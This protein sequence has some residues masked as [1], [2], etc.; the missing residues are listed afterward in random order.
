MIDVV[1]ETGIVHKLA[2]R[3]SKAGL[4]GSRIIW[5][6]AKLLSPFPEG[7][8]RLPDGFLLKFD[9]RDWNHRAIY[10]GL[11]DRALCRLVSKIKFK[12]IFIDVGANV[13]YISYLTC[14]HKQVKCLTIEPISRNSEQ[15]KFSLN[16]LDIPY[17]HISA[18]VADFNGYS[19]I[20]GGQNPDHSGAASIERV[21]LGKFG[22]EHVPTFLLDELARK[23]LSQKEISSPIFVKID[24]EGAEARVIAGMPMLLSQPNFFGMIIE[25]SPNFGSIEYLRH[26]ERILSK[27]YECFLIKEKVKLVHAQVVATKISWAMALKLSTQENLLIVKDHN[28]ISGLKFSSS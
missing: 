6:I 24:T 12:G 26:L 20:F 13:G 3:Y 16:E 11:Y 17:R 27:D 8:V 18:A 9:S 25:V 14:R 10:Q 4:R 1:Q 28:A 21:S 7:W 2:F 22:S 5:T 19:E 23:Y 15:L